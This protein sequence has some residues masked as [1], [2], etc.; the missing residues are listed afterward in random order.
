MKTERRHELQTNSLAE[1]LNEAGE[2][3]KPYAKGILGVA[4]A[5]LVIFGVYL[6]LSKQADAEVA[7]GWDQTFQA[8]G[9]R[10][11]TEA[12]EGLRA[13]A[14]AHPN[15]PSGV[16]AQL[17]LA[18][19]E[20]DLG[21]QRLF[22]ERSVGRANLSAALDD[23]RA[24][25]DRAKDQLVRQHAFYGIGRTNES[26]DKLDDATQAYENLLKEFPNGPYQD[27]AKQRVDQLS[28]A[29]SKDWY[30]WFR[31]AEPTPNVFGKDKSSPFDPPGKSGEKSIFDMPDLK[32]PL[33]V[34]PP[35]VPD[36]PRSD[37]GKPKSAT[38]KSPAGEPGEPIITKP[39]TS[40]DKKSALPELPSKSTDPAPDALKPDAAK[41]DAAKPDAAKPD[42]AK[43]DV[44]KPEA[45]KP[46]A[47]K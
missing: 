27:R 20:F 37:S 39:D 31:R 40:L 3:A 35:A 2:N 18:D 33:D 17:V 44:A 15:K 1:I 10:N 30:D 29:S 42:A 32:L 38:D 36:S 5:A 24:V 19:T 26:L 16:W 23:Y 47:G 22:T 25:L 21:V 14:D 7:S 45:A 34:K 4:L 9:Q 6:Y 11:P 28:Q 43:P 46:E 13:A 41:P 8:M 12:L